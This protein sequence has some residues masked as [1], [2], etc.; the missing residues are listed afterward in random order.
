MNHNE[1][2][3][4]ILSCMCE[5]PP[6]F[7]IFTNFEVREKNDFDSLVCPIIRGNAHS[8]SVETVMSGRLIKSMHAQCLLNFIMYLNHDN[9]ISFYSFQWNFA[10]FTL[11]NDVI[12]IASCIN[13]A[14]AHKISWP[15]EVERRRLLILNPHFWGVALESLMVFLSNPKTLEQFKLCQMV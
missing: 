12:F 6:L 13:N 1:G 5:V 11:C 14:F 8:T 10:C 9:V 7:K 4:N 15:D 2:V 3:M